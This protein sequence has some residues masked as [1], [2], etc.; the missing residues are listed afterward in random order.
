MSPAL[1]EVR[2]QV[3]KAVI[4]K[5]VRDLVCQRGGVVGEVSFEV[6]KQ[7]GGLPVMEPP[8][9]LNEVWEVIKV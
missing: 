2:E 6:P 3:F 4:G 9:C 8:E 1:L 5:D 7:E